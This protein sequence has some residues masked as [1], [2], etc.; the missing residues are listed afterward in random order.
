MLVV[1]GDSSPVDGLYPTSQWR[2]NTL[3]EDHR[4]LS[5]DAPLPAGEYRVLIGLYRLSDGARL[6]ITPDARVSNDS[7][8]VYEW[9]VADSF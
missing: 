1:Q 7:V 2:L 6:P 9:L 3:I 4:S 8:Q 5:L